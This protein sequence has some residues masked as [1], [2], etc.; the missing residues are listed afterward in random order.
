MGKSSID[1]K[2]VYTPR[3]GEI[4][5][6]RGDVEGKTTQWALQM[7]QAGIWIPRMDWGIQIVGRII[8]SHFPTG[9]DDRIDQQRKSIDLMLDHLKD[10]CPKLMGIGDCKHIGKVEGQPS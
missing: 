8:G 2:A 6:V 5:Y 10:H 9:L 3:K 7:T 1:R 4:L